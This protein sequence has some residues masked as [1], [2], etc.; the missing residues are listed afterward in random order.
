MFN[1]TPLRRGFR[2]ALPAFALFFPA[3]AF[4]QSAYTIIDLGTLG[5][6][7]SLGNAINASGQVAGDSQITGSA[8]YNAYSYSGSTL[9]GLGT[10][11][12]SASYGRGINDGGTVAGYAYTAGNITLHATIWNGTTITDL[13]TLG[14]ANSYGRGINASGQVVGQS[15]TASNT[16]YHAT[17]W[18]GTS[19]TDLGTL[20][21]SS[22]VGYAINN[23]GQVAG[24]AALSG[25][26]ATHA[27][28]W[29]GTTPTDLGTLS[30]GTTSAGYAINASGLVAGYSTTT[31]GSSHAA[32]WNGTSVTDIGTLAGGN[33]FAYGIDTLG[34]VVGSSFG[35]TGAAFLYKSGSLMNLNTLIPA[36][37]GWKLTAANAINDN[38]L[39]T[40][41][42]SI[43]G[44][45]HAFLL[46]PNAAGT[47]RALLGAGSGAWVCGA[48]RGIEET[49]TEVGAARG[50]RR[51]ES[52]LCFNARLVLPQNGSQ[53]KIP[54]ATHLSLSAPVHKLSSRHDF[55]SVIFCLFQCEPGQRR[56]PP[57]RAAP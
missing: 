20:G 28:R 46:K 5:G 55:N 39:I 17:V 22:S 29:N 31:D 1:T 37:S 47:P 52:G 16:T 44:A 10:L 32:L 35:S 42:G 57:D 11:G 50:E 53:R 23:S 15:Q 41:V 38:G 34:D 30:G 8:A 6:Q 13:G 43:N 9:T 7:D 14:G 19:P 2:V 25:D 12:G 49:Q 51:R 33:S 45:T 36:G 18:N 40:G 48:W 54:A 24:S 56:D 26:S 4:A 3:A 21:G 27:V